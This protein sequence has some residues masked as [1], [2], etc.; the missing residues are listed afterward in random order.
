MYIAIIIYILMSTTQTSENKN[1]IVEVSTNDYV[2]SPRSLPRGKH[3]GLICAETGEEVHR[4]YS[5]EDTGFLSY[6]KQMWFSSRFNHNLHS[7]KNQLDP[8]DT[9][10]ARVNYNSI[11]SKYTEEKPSE[12]SDSSSE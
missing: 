2:W 8:Y 5:P 7:W 10:S 11:F 6:K 3:G 4:D 1:P 12:T 9:P